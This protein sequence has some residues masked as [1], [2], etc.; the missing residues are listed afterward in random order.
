VL[1]ND[2]QAGEEQK[3]QSRNFLDAEKLQLHQ[4]IVFRLRSNYLNLFFLTINSRFALKVFLQ[5]F[6]MSARKR[7][8]N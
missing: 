6:S 2:N 8:Q 4:K 1:G 7:L 5:Q 3:W